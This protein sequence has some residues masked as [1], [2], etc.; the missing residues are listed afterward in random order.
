MKDLTYVYWG[1]FAF[2]TFFLILACVAAICPQQAS[3]TRAVF[4]LLPQTA[5]LGAVGLALLLQGMFFLLRA[6]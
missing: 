2:G 4:R 3:G 6:P 5:L 1:E